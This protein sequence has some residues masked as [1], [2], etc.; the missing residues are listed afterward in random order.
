MNSR[1]NIALSCYTSY[2]ITSTLR[3]VILLELLRRQISQDLLKSVLRF[4]PRLKYGGF[5]HL[6]RNQLSSG[7]ITN[8]VHCHQLAHKVIISVIMPNPLLSVRI[9]IDLE[10][11]LPT[12]RGERSRTTI[13]ALRQFLAPNPENEILSIKRRLSDVEKQLE[14]LRSPN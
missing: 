1:T 7:V 10:K 5:N 3:I 8:L 14:G 12:D 11:L 13:E 6:F 2:D 4:I 9:P